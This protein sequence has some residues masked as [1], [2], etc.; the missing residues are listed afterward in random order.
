MSRAAEST[1]G[2][3][4]GEEPP[5][6]E[7]SH[8]GQFLCGFGLE[9]GHEP[10]DRNRIEPAGDAEHDVLVE[11]EVGFQGARTAGEVGPEPEPVDDEPEV[12]SPV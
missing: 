1:C 5:V 7:P 2:G 4:Q 12:V 9:L 3:E 11:P 10:G 6:T 8:C